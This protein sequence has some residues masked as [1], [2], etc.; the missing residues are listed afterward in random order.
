MKQVVLK[1][2]WFRT[3]ERKTEVRNNFGFMVFLLYFPECKNYRNNKGHMLN[4]E[5]NLKGFPL[6]QSE[7]FEHQ[8]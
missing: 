8:R 7:N 3:V 5:D 6:A 2:S 4:T 1:G